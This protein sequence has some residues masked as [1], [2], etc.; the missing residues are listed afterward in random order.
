MYPVRAVFDGCVTEDEAC[1]ELEYTDPAHPDYVLCAPS[2]IFKGTEADRAVFDEGPGYK[3]TECFPTTLKFAF[4]DGETLEVAQYGDGVQFAEGTL[5]QESADAAPTPLPELATI[6]GLTGPDIAVDLGGPTTQYTSASSESAYF[7]TPGHVV[8]VDLASG[9]AETLISY[10]PTDPQGPASVV[11]DEDPHSVAY[12]GSDLWVARAEA[13]T[14]DQVGGDGA[15]LGSIALDHPP[16]ALAVD[17]ETIWATSFDDS[18]VMRVN[19]E[20]GRLKPRWICRTRPGSPSA[21]EASG[22]WNTAMESWRVSI[23]IRTK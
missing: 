10:E 23:R 12:D 5:E 3:S 22:W 9:V 7:P 14:L 16:Y 1:G 18:V 17:D 15:T 21:A 13:R 2:L 4:V 11:H 6:D 8:K 19:T 20:T